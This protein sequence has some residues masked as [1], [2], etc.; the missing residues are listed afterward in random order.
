[1]FTEAIGIVFAVI[2]GC[3]LL[4]QGEIDLEAWLAFFLFVPMIN[5]VLRQFSMMWT[6]IKEIQGRAARMGM[7][8]DAPQEDTARSWLLCSCLMPA[9]PC[10]GRA[11]LSCL[12]RSIL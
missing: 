4:R 10:S 9:R 5:T 1:M 7:L 12:N 8:M 6:N 2:W 11:A 3:M